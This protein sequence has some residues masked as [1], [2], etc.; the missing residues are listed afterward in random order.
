MRRLEVEITV[1]VLAKKDGEVLMVSNKPEVGGKPAGWGFPGG[2]ILTDEQKKRFGDFQFEELVD[3][4]LSHIKEFMGRYDI[5]PHYLEGVLSSTSGII[6]DEGDLVGVLIY[7]TAIREGLEETGLLFR[8]QSIAFDEMV[9]M[10]HRVVTVTAEIVAGEIVK[11]TDE[12][13]DCAW[14]DPN[15][16]PEGSY[17]SHA[18]R[19]ETILKGEA[20][21]VGV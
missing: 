18:R 7:L 3:S 8:P 4:A 12:T 5:P 2:S 16:L 21:Y 14:V 11:V 10:D 6:R 13:N 19:L 1:H 15:N 20:A 9:A 17:R